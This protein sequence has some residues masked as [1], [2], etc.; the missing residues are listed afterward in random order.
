[1]ST[2]VNEFE[3]RMGK[4]LAHELEE[5]IK[6]R[7]K[8]MVDE[9]GC[10]ISL[11]DVDDFPRVGVITSGLSE[12][13][14]KISDAKLRTLATFLFEK[15]IS[16]PGKCLPNL[17]LLMREIKRCPNIREVLSFLKELKNKST[18]GMVAV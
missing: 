9:A 2:H 3:K 11:T 16:A 14:K 4:K 13:W 12:F 18:L 15:I 17:R 10:G 6:E 8:K 5:K 7:R 1:M